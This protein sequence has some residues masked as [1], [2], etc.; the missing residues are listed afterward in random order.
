MARCRSGKKLQDWEDP[1]TPAGNNVTAST[2]AAIPA[3]TLLVA[4]TI[5]GGGTA[6]IPQ[7]FTDTNNQTWTRVGRTA[8][9]NPS[10]STKVPSI[11]YAVQSTS[12]SAGT[13]STFKVRI[14]GSNSLGGLEVFAITG[15]KATSPLDTY[16]Q[17]AFSSAGSFTLTTGAL[18]AAHEV[19]IMTCVW[20]NTA[21]FTMTQG[22]GFTLD[23]V[24][25]TNGTSIYFG[26]EHTTDTGSSTSS[27]SATWSV[28][29]NNSTAG[30]FAVFLS[31]N[32]NTQNLSATVTP[33]GAMSLATAKGLSATLQAS[34][35]VQKAVAKGVSATLTATGALTRSISKGLTATLA[36]SG[37]LARGIT[38][39]LS[40][41]L[42]GLAGSLS[43]GIAKG[44]SGSLSMQGA[45]SR[46]ISKVLAGTL[47]PTG[48]L[49]VPAIRAFYQVASRAFSFITS[50]RPFSFAAPPRA[51]AF[52]ATG[53]GMTAIAT[54]QGVV[55]IRT[56]EKNIG[57]Q[58]NF[59]GWLQGGETISTASAIAKAVLLSAPTTDLSANAAA[60]VQSTTISGSVV[61]V[62]LGNANAVL[63]AVYTVTVAITTSAGRVYQE[64]FPAISCDA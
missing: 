38:R 12:I 40:A 17:S 60:M 7:S 55:V 11:Y 54:T 34:G 53:T 31:A 20:N 16:V 43:R 18:A 35:T 8:F 52:L 22:S 30:V 56:Q 32:T 23:A 21:N 44:L 28:S 29:P 37:S 10:G 62:S 1:H 25:P 27:A 57:Y 59:S 45:I 14:T 39:N 3:G 13:T 50:L 48:S 19:G 42:S 58:L 49:I 33:S 63:D 51:F 4:C 41:S 46:G 15:A 36:S 24:L 2:T 47:R 26:D 64:S 5:N 6:A 61:T 9:V